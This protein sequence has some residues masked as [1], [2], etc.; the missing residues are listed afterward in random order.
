MESD[1][2]KCERAKRFLHRTK[3]N[4]IFPRTT[5]SC[6][7]ARVSNSLKKKEGKLFSA[8]RSAIQENFYYKI[9]KSPLKCFRKMATIQC[10]LIAS[11]VVLMVMVHQGERIVQLQSNDDFPP[12]VKIHGA[13]VKQVQISFR[14]KYQS[15]LHT[16]VIIKLT[17]VIVSDVMQY[18]HTY[19][20]GNL[21]DSY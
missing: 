16:A 15:R 19:Q 11:A 3:K 6:W 21:I 1:K 4:N 7:S 5:H 8:F 14:C 2:V 13:F 18:L 12:S 17:Q 10:L 9:L 20:L